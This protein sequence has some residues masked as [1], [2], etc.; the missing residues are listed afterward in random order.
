MEV[1]ADWDQS[2]VSAFFLIC[3][4]VFEQFAALTS[5]TKGSD[6]VKKKAGGKEMDRDLSDFLSRADAYYT[7]THISETI[8]D[9]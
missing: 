2:V 1:N 9:P 5:S 7:T 8:K 6:R 4:S 3:V